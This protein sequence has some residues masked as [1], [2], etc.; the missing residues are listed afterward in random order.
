MANPTLRVTLGHRYSISRFAVV[1]LPWDC[2]RS[3]TCPLYAAL[4]QIHFVVQK[5]YLNHMYRQVK[6]GLDQSTRFWS[7]VSIQSSLL[8]TRQLPTPPANCLHPIQNPNVLSAF[9]SQA[10][11]A[12]PGLVV[13]HPSPNNTQSNPLLKAS[14]S[15]PPT[16]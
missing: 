9:H 1:S 11:C 5:K 16:H 10:L 13:P 12:S 8:S 3:F 2:K 15:V 14:V 6:S 4:K 7:D